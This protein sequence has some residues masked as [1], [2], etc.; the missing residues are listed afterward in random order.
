[1]IKTPKD[2]AQYRDHFGVLIIQK[3]PILVEILTILDSKRVGS[4]PVCRYVL[5]ARAML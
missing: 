5:S 2:S 4:N 3:D 1:M